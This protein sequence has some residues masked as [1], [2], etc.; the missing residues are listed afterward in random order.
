MSNGADLHTH[1]VFSDGM[2]TPE[3]NVRMALEAGLAAI[4]ITDHDTVA[5]IPDALEAGR[6]LG[7]VVV[8]GVE[9]ST[10]SNGKDIHIL[11]Y[12]YTLDDPVWL[13]RLEAL[14]NLRNSRNEAILANLERLGIPI[15]ADDLA[16]AAGKSDRRDKSVGRPHIAQALVDKGFVAD[17]REAFDKYLAE[18]KPAYA[19]QARLAPDEAIRW[20]HEA[21]GKAVIAHPGIYG[22]DNLV[23]P[24]LDAGADGIEAYHSEHDPEQ[25]S[26]YAQWAAMRGIMA[27]GGSDF[28]G[29]KNG[30]A[31]HGA[32]GARKVDAEIAERLIRR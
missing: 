23:L 14:R 19:A 8:P 28:H 30:E 24:I 32:I 11:G 12:G 22:A 16:H 21:G 2:F 26:R 4:A 5:G 13:G 25:E 31:F 29:V 18:G 17:V 3:T 9:L 6:K 10:S 27:T 1:T 7:I 20:I 15:T